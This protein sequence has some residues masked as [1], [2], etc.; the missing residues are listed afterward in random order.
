M[1]RSLIYYVFLNGLPMAE[2][3]FNVFMFTGKLE[4]KRHA[5][6][7]FFSMLILFSLALV[8]F[9]HVYYTRIP[10]V[11]STTHFL[12]PL[13]CYFTM[14]ISCVLTMRVSFYVPIGSTLFIIIMGI[15]AMT[16]EKYLFYLILDCMGITMHEDA[17]FIQYY[18]LRFLFD[19]LLALALYFLLARNVQIHDYKKLH[20]SL[21][22]VIAFLSQLFIICTIIRVDLLGMRLINIV[23]DLL[24]FSVATLILIVVVG[25]LQNNQLA[26][27]INMMKNIWHQQAQQTLAFQQSIDIINMKYHDLKY[28]MN[29][30]NDGS[31][32]LE[33]GMDEETAEVL[34][35]YDS[36]LSVGNKTLDTVLTQQRLK[37]EHEHIRFSC[38]ADGSLL[39]F[40]SVTDTC[41]LFGNALDNAI[42]AV[43]KLPEEKRLISLQIT[44][45]KNMVSVRIENAC[46]G[47]VSFQGKMPL[48][49]KKNTDYHGFGTR[50]MQVIT[51]KY[52]GD[53]CFE[54]HDGVFTVSILFPNGQTR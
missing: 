11:S 51:E 38:I 54:Y 19:L 53:I 12:L 16:L 18:V 49:S 2:L 33:H 37:C 24:I 43:S 22:A 8:A 4:R 32:S 35:V 50:S 42:E 30:L 5:A 26:G 40:L 10:S 39:S 45:I 28:R 15:S 7:R 36:M 14:Q 52:H 48:T 41:V 29:A 9:V 3:Y 20:P 31:H 25:I 47:F 27:E 44:N 6:L 46:Q 17:V 1:E 34:N 13:F 23:F 21:F